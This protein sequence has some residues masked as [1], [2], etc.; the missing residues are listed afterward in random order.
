MLITC[1]FEPRE[2]KLVACGGIDTKLHIYAINP[3]GKKKEKL[4]LIEKVKELSGH[5]GLV[6]CCGFL[7]SQ[8]LVSGSNDASIMLWDF[9]KPGRFLVKYSDH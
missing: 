2:G 9:E 6:T 1:A 7:S 3:S 4:N 5:Y 8:F